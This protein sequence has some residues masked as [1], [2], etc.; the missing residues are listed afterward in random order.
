MQKKILQ[1]VSTDTVLA[2]WKPDETGLALNF[3]VL[4]QKRVRGFRENIWNHEAARW[5]F[6][7]FSSVWKPDETRT[8]SFWNNFSSNEKIS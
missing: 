3:E 6:L 7:L 4:F 1:R 5:V 2:V 8:T